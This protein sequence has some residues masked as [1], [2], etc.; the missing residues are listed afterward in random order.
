METALLGKIEKL[1]AILIYYR[2]IWMHDISYSFFK[3]SGVNQSSE[4]SSLQISQFVFSDM[5]ENAITR[6]YTVR[7]KRSPSFNVLGYDA[8]SLKVSNK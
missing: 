5:S 8:A 4:I 6:Q 3:W 7:Q 1:S 2:R